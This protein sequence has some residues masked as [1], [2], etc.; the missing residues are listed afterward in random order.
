MLPDTTMK[1]LFNAFE[2][3]YSFD[4]KNYRFKCENKDDIEESDTV[5]TLNLKDGGTIE[6]ILKT[7]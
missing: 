2:E 6:A 1:E 7:V 3:K 5:T 4:I